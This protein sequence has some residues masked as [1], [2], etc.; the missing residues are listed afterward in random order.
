MNTWSLT[1]AAAAA[2]LAIAP[3][4]RFEPPAPFAPRATIAHYNGA[5]GVNLPLWDL[6]NGDVPAVVVNPTCPT[7]APF[8]PTT[9]N[10]DNAKAVA[11]QQWGPILNLGTCV[12]GPGNAFIRLRPTCVNGT[13]LTLPGGC[14]G[15]VL[16]AGALLG[17]ITAP[18]NG[19]T[20]NVPNQAIPTSAVGFAWTAQASVREFGTVRT[21]LSSLLFGV[22]D[23]AF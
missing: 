18:H 13:T 10:T 22:V 5:T 14:L 19:V 6:S 2:T 20:C 9:G 12:T 4:P 23:I 3:T 17:M 16:Q 7:P 21:E 11:S 1:L 8:G 15:Q